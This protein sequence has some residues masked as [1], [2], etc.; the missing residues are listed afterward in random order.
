MEKNDILLI[1]LVHSSYTHTFA[2]KNMLSEPLS[3]Y[4]KIFESLKLIF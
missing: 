2:L 4:T 3:E 1:A